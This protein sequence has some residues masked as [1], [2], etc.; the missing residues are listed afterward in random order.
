MINRINQ[1]YFIFLLII[2]YLFFGFGYIFDIEILNMLGI[3]LSIMLTFVSTAENAFIVV[4]SLISLNNFFIINNTSVR[5]L[6]YLI[7][8]IKILYSF[9]KTKSFKCTD[10]KFIICFFLICLTEIYNELLVGKVFSLINILCG[11]LFF[12]TYLIYFSRDENCKRIDSIEKFII[13]GCLFPL[14]IMIIKGGGIFSYNNDISYYRFGQESLLLG[15]PMGAVIY[16]SVI[17]GFSIKNILINNRRLFNIILLLFS[18]IL[19][20]LTISRTF[21]VICIAI[22]IVLLIYL[23]FDKRVKQNI[24]YLLNNSNT[25]YVLLTGLVIFVFFVLFNFNFIENVIGKFLARTTNIL[26]DPRIEIAKESII[27][28]IKNPIHFFIGFGNAGYQYL[29]ELYNLSFSMYTHNIYLDVLMSWGMIGMIA[30]IYSLYLFLKGKI[31]SSLISLLPYTL[32]LIAFLVNGL[33]GGTFNYLYNYALLLFLI[34][35]IKENNNVDRN[36]NLS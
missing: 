1:R 25:K 23:I 8:A 7:P 16:S 28:L 5:G 17:I 32:P 30:L 33:F 27:Y 24:K 9:C 35:I 18:T 13:L 14:I 12:F 26:N 29:G 2:N 4:L 11:I 20:F 34:L 3:I 15:G 10:I 36:N 22:C 21:L 19:G 31:K 6:I